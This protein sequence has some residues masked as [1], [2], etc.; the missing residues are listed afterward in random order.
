MET[1]RARPV[2]S[3]LGL[4]DAVVAADPRAAEDTLE[5]LSRGTIL[6]GSVRSTSTPLPTVASSDRVT[7]TSTP[8]GAS[9]AAGEESL[10][11][12]GSRL[13]SPQRRRRIRRRRRFHRDHR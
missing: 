2:L 6:A 11:E 4:H 7:T 5:E 10:G 3:G 13:H 1:Y 9:A 12:L 8:G